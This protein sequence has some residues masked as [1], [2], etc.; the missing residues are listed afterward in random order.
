M[1]DIEKYP[2]SGVIVRE[3]VMVEGEIMR[4][5]IRALARER[6]QSPVARAN[7]K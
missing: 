1:D 2:T 3:P 4:G 5:L 7:L 6:V